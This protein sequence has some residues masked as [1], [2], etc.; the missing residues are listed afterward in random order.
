MTPQRL[1]G[2]RFALEYTATGRV[3]FTSLAP[4]PRRA[5]RRLI[6][7]LVDDPYRNGTKQ[8]LGQPEGRRRAAFGNRRIIYQVRANAGK[9]IIEH[10]GPRSTIYQGDLGLPEGPPPLR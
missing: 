6:R 1:P 2:H 10:I 5:A 3:D 7:E 8:L 4:A 9:V